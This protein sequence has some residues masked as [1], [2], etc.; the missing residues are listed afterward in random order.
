MLNIAVY[1]YTG[2]QGCFKI[3]IL[4][5]VFL[6]EKKTQFLAGF[7]KNLVQKPGGFGTIS[8]GR[9]CIYGSAAIV[10]FFLG[11]CPRTMLKI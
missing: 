1:I 7:F 10:S 5:T 3:S 8:M 11:F 4:G 6:G 2:Y 9:T